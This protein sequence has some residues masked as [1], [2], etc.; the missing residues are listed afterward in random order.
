MF[1]EIVSA[2]G[3]IWVIDNESVKALSDNPSAPA[4][5]LLYVDGISIPISFAGT[6]D[7]VIEILDLYSRFSFDSEIVIRKK[8]REKAMREKALAL[9]KLEID[10]AEKSSAIPGLLVEDDT[11]LPTLA[12]DLKD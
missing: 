5:T 10:I 8:A 4:Q 7:E 11:A 2:D 6:K 3:K 1:K 12:D 9:E